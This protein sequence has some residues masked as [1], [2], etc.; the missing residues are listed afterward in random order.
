M[1]VTGEHFPGQSED[2]DLG[3]RLVIEGNARVDHSLYSI[4]GWPVRMVQNVVYIAARDGRKNYFFYTKY[5][6]R[7][8]QMKF[9]LSLNALLQN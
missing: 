9:P 4:G 1:L 8:V 3:A 6:P 7:L 2:V 5:Q